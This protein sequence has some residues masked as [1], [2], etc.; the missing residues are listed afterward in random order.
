MGSAYHGKAFH[1]TALLFTLIQVKN[2][3]DQM[4]GSG[5]GEGRSGFNGGEGGGLIRALAVRP[6]GRSLF[7]GPGTGFLLLRAERQAG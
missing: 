5:D 6:G 3:E 4:L 2:G 7:G 1:R